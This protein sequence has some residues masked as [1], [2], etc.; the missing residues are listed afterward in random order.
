[1]V[2]QPQI[3]PVE[4]VG[5]EVAQ[6][7]LA[8][9][10][11][12][13]RDQRRQVVPGADDQSLWSVAG[14]AQAGPVGERPVDEDV[15]P[16]ANVQRG[17]L[18]AVVAALDLPRGPPG[19]VGLVLDPVEVEV[20]EPV[21]PEQ[22]Q[23]AQGPVGEPGARVGRGREQRRLQVGRA[24]AGLVDASSI[25]QP[26]AKA[27]AKAPPLYSQPVRSCDGAR[28]GTAARSP[29]GSSAAVSSCDIPG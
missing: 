19:A 10:D 25:A 23:V 13:G 5:V 8:E 11:R 21:A 28:A 12:S 18:D 15:V 2:A 6:A 22:R 29:S 9:G 1:V 27:S 26:S 20:A 3:E 4:L 14:E 17:Y 24:P 7:R 16:A